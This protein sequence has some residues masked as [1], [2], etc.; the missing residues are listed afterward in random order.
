MTLSRVGVIGAGTMGN[1]IVQICAAAGLQVA[2][3]DVA[4][5]PLA[6]GLSAIGSS[7][8]RLVKKEKLGPGERE[9][10]LARIRVG[11]DY[12]L[13]SAAD[14]VIEA[15]TKNLEIKRGILKRADEL[16]RPK[17]ILATNTSSISITLAAAT[18]RPER[19][20]A[21]IYLIQCR[22]CRCWN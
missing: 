18:S 14:L 19:S 17:S 1:G 4:E 8:D 10:I 22:S 6:Q 9:E 21:C 5:A 15:A 20:L 12:A 2:M 3:V 13:L 16:L 7:L 11:T